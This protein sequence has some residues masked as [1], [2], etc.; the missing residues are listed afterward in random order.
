MTGTVA[1]VALVALVV[2]GDLIAATAGTEAS[3]SAAQIP[4]PT[5]PIPIARAL[6]PAG[7]GA[8]PPAREV[9]P[10][11]REIPR[12][13][14]PP[15]ASA[16]VPSRRAADGRDDSTQSRSILRRNQRSCPETRRPEQD[17]FPAQASN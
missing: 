9:A 3:A 16:Y 15:F 6:R 12:I 11:A 7:P 14:S 4:V 5:S 13:R 10:A 17:V 8:A 2:A 1:L